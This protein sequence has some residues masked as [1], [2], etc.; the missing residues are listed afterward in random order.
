MAEWTVQQNKRLGWYYAVVALIA[1]VIAFIQQPIS[2]WGIFGVLIGV[3]LL[4]LGLMG[5]RQGITGKGNTRSSTMSDS[6]QRTWAIVGL[7]G[8]SLAGVSIIFS[9][10]S[11]WTASDTLTVGVWV[12]LA[13][14]FISQIRTLA[15]T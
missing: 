1:I 15:R 2:E 13:G 10:M 6:R 11:D 12:A 4:L 8:V 5:L 9:N 7:I 14:L 3:A